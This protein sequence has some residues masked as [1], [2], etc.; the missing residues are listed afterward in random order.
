MSD[1]LKNFV[2]KTGTSLIGLVCK[3]GI[4]LGADRQVTAG[5]IVTNKNYKKIF[6]I[7]DYLISAYTGMV[8]DAQFLNRLVAAELKLKE[9]KSKERPSVKESAVFLST[10]TFRNVRQFS[11]IPSI[12]GTLVAGYD[13][14]GSTHLYS[15]E[16]AGGIYE[17]EDY[18]AN[19][20]AGMPYI[21]GILER[22][23]KKDLSVEEGVKLAI[24]SLKAAMQRDVASGYG[25]DIFTVTKDGIKQV[26]SEELVQELKKS[27]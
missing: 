5:T 19:F 27:K 9:L 20:S 2:L 11:T 4:V 21:L 22:S 6:R 23:Y 16:P 8:S 10:I 18:D 7:N 1:E 15:I 3:D 26:I 13:E 17:V 12:V 25:V 24:D 14:D